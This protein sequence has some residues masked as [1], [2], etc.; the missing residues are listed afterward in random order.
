M[1]ANKTDADYTELCEKEGWPV[2]RSKVDNKWR[3]TALGVEYKLVHPLSIYFKLFRI[4][5]NPELKYHYMK[6]CHD[7]LWPHHEKYWNYWTERRFKEHCSDSIYISYAGGASSGKSF[8]G[9][10]IAL[11]YWLADPEHRAVVVA[12]TTLKSLEKRIWGYIATLIKEVAVPVPYFYRS[13]PTPSITFREPEVKQRGDAKDIRHGMMAVSA[14]RGDSQESIKDWIG[15]HPD[16][17]LLII[18]DEGTDM[19]I[20]IL[21]ATPNLDT[22]QGGF[23]MM[24]IGNS[25]SRFD[26]HGILS[27]PKEGWDSIDPMRDV[28]WLTTQK[29]GVCLF[30]GCYDSPSLHETDPDKREALCTFLIKPEA[31]EEKEKNPGKTSDA[32]YRFVLGFWRNSSTDPTIITEKFLLDYKPG[33]Y[34]EWSGIYP[35][36]YCAGLDI[37]FATDNGGDNCVLRLAKLSVDITGKVVMDYYKDKLLFYIPVSS[38]V[39]E[40]AELQ[41]CKEVLRI[42][43]EYKIPLHHLCYDASGSGRAMGETLRLTAMAQN[44]G[45]PVMPPI[46]IISVRHGV[47]QKSQDE[48]VIIKSNYDLW[49]TFRE[50][51]QQRQIKGM[52]TLSTL[53]MTTRLVSTDEKTK[54]VT[55]ET[56]AAYKKRM[57]GIMPELARSPDEADSAS[58]ALQSAIQIYNFQPGQTR[59]ISGGMDSVRENAKIQNLINTHQAQEYIERSK[60]NGPIKMHVRQANFTT[61]ITKLASARKL[62]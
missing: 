24:I 58:L 8:D 44:P 10:K 25:C 27:T 4:E 47:Q 21:D 9:A 30:F 51:Y 56:K 7:F 26:L 48:G 39:K 46:K 13:S 15:I 14:K 35:I 12:S 20:A 6:K 38:G 34:A 50:Y 54:R 41:I 42:L 61:D 2:F 1:I 52:D 57:G 18:L 22:A 16:N 59:A 62:F 17:G 43:K 53:Q 11:L 36:N 49:F 28:R 5:K 45:V 3:V 37:S 55:L 23:Q 29:K 60:Q 40:S 32:F 19:P 33:E 31:L